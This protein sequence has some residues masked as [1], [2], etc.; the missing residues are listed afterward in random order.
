MLPLSL[1]LALFLGTLGWV[2]YLMA[3]PT[4]AIGGDRRLW[5]I[6]LGLSAFVAVASVLAWFRRPTIG[7]AVGIVAAFLSILTYWSL[8]LGLPA[9]WIYHW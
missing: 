5:M 6:A 2:A 8:V 7:I 9:A 3:D 4:L 1:I